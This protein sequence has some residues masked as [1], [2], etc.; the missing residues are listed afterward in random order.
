[1]TL[2][3]SEEIRKT[4][5]DRANAYVRASK[6]S[7][8]AIGLAAVGDSKFL[9]RVENGLGFNINTYQRVI[10]WL[11]TAERELSERETAA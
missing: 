5:I 1:M 8:S 10:D 6:S 11:E 7:F 3:T 2:I 9:S 4:L